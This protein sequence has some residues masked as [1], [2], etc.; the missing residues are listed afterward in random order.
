[1]AAIQKDSGHAQA[2]KQ[3]AD[4]STLK[5][6]AVGADRFVKTAR[7]WT[8]SVAA[9]RFGA[10][11][12]TY[13]AIPVPSGT[14]FLYPGE[15]Q[16]DIDIEAMR[17]V[18]V[19]TVSVA[20]RQALLAALEPDIKAEGYRW[21]LQKQGLSAADF[22]AMR[23]AQSAQTLV[24]ADGRTVNHWQ[25]TVDDFWGTISWQVGKGRPQPADLA[26]YR[27]GQGG[28]RDHILAWIVH[29]WHEALKTQILDVS[30]D[31]PVLPFIP[32][33]KQLSLD[34]QAAVPLKELSRSE[35]AQLRR[36]WG[37]NAEV[38]AKLSKIQPGD[39]Y[40]FLPATTPSSSEGGLR[41]LVEVC[42]KHYEAQLVPDPWSAYQP[43]DV[44][45]PS[46]VKNLNY[47]WSPEA[48]A[49]WNQPKHLGRL[50][51]KQVHIGTYTREGTYRAALEKLKAAKSAAEKQGQ[52]FEFT[53]IQFN[54]LS[55]FAGHWNWGYDGTYYFA[56]ENAYG[57]PE[58]LQELVNWCH[59]NQLAVVFD[60][61]L[62]HFGPEG[63]YLGEYGGRLFDANGSMGSL[64]GNLRWENPTALEMAK[65]TVR[66][67]VEN[68]RADGIRFDL[69]EK[70]PD[71]CMQE[72]CKDIHT[73]KSNVGLIYEDYRPQDNVTLPP[74]IGL[75]ANLQYN[76]WTWH[77]LKEFLEGQASQGKA[78][79]GH[80]YRDIWQGLQ[81]GTQGRPL[82]SG[83]T[84]LMNHDTLGNDWRQRLVKAL[85][86]LAV[87]HG[88][89]AERGYDLARLGAVLHQLLPGTTL[90]FQGE[91]DGRESPLN[92]FTSFYQL[93]TNHG[94]FLGRGAE[95]KPEFDA[96]RA[97]CIGPDSF[98]ESKLSQSDGRKN[99]GYRKLFHAALALRKQTP[100]LWQGGRNEL[101]FDAFYQGNRALMN[102]HRQDNVLLLHRRGRQL[103]Q[104][105]PPAYL[106]A[107]STPDS[108]ALVVANFS[109][110]DQDVEVPFPGGAAGWR[111][112]LN[113][114]K[115][116]YGG[117][118]RLQ[119][120]ATQI[121]LLS[122]AAGRPVNK[123]LLPARTL[124]VY[125]KGDEGVKNLAGAT[126]S[127]LG[128]S[129]ETAG[130][131]LPMPPLNDEAKT[132]VLNHF[133]LV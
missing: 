109:D 87:E 123:V 89:P 95:A 32:K 128:T 60:L 104:N 2:T 12:P 62:N 54:P 101:S 19:R 90:A 28:D 7:P 26:R 70:I 8:P 36:H 116:E 27:H 114:D 118:G 30:R 73:F 24:L 111:E 117:K 58:D 74:N 64:G 71:Y 122:S 39:F 130:R 106:R 3:S 78:S 133:A 25:K 23:A 75:G 31:P 48:T 10:F 51:L 41:Y 83:L 21:W 11:Y 108:E 15:R 56:P 79:L 68:F 91:D 40:G 17:V 45:G 9:L 98:L 47:A 59:E 42:K 99:E 34:W 124:V 115:V 18:P 94:V 80:L 127:T 102:R 13:G 49:F 84:Y 55:E 96:G 132:T 37:G 85:K 81:G 72:I 52:P 121:R 38:T 97:G 103:P 16:G 126:L 6:A 35:I 63:N 69:S 113:T 14:L 120:G 125:V 43:L 4:V 107:L 93:D 44:H 66:F 61:V 82:E 46:Q 57:P 86:T 29:Q 110:R 22:Q 5:N 131:L 129:G 112:A 65:Q 76:S 67:W 20:D 92:F 88:Q 119:H 53:G 33:D 1:M 105:I 50:M 77:G 100:A